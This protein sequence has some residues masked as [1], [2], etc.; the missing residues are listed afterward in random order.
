MLTGG[1]MVNLLVYIRENG[2]RIGNTIY[3]AKL[4]AYSNSHW[5]VSSRIKYSLE[6]TMELW[7]Y[8]SFSVSID[9]LSLFLA[10]ALMLQS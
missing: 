4:K 2:V 7:L 6:L 9:L 1:F 10:M 5:E 8:Y 3:E